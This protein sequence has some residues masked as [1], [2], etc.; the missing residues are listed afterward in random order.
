MA[1]VLVVSDI[2]EISGEFSPEVL[3][4]FDALDLRVVDSKAEELVRYELELVEDLCTN[5]QASLTEEHLLR[6]AVFL[7]AKLDSLQ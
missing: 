3:A 6:I 4:R 1:N 7:N 2:F 5:T